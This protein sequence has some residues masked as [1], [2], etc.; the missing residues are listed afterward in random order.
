MSSGNKSEK[1]VIV[2]FGWIGQ[3]NALAL[4][5]M[6]F[7]V[8]YY[9][10]ITPNFH[11]ADKYQEL[12]K[13]IK[14]LKTLLEV[15]SQNTWYIVCIGDRV[16]ED[17]YQ[18]I[19]L[20]EQALEPLRFARGK[21]ILRSTVLP[22]YLE[23]LHFHI[24][25]PEFLH[26]LYAVE[27]CLNPF[28]YVVGVREDFEYPDFFK[29]WEDR[30]CKIFKG[31]PEEA[32]HIKY[33]S[34]IWNAMR[35][36]FVNEFG[37]NIAIPRSEE[38]FYKVERVVDFFFEK[39]SY[40][41]YGKTFDGHCLPKDMR[42]FMTWKG[43]NRPVPLLKAIYQSNQIHQEVVD[44]YTLPKW[45][46]AWDYNVYQKGIKSR[47]KRWW[48][49]LNSV[50]AVQ[51]VRHFVRPVVRFFERLVPSK[52]PDQLKT[53]WN[54]WAKE[55]PYYYTNPDTK[56]GKKADEFEIRQTGQADYQRYIS[57]DPVLQQHM[58]G[59]QEKTVLE[60]GTGV[61]R[62]TEYF[63]QDFKQVHGIDISP[64]MLE[65]AKKRMASF[66]NVN[67]AETVGNIIPFDAEQFDLIFSY[68]V[69]KHLRRKQIIADYFKE[70]A[71]AL[72][73]DGLVKVQL[74]TG[75]TPHVWHWFYG[76]SLFLEEAKALAE[77]SGFEI[78]KSEIENPKSMWLWLKKS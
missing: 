17:G 74:R 62:M 31:T 35:I 14:P 46:S 70:M 11:Y 64:V 36:A 78:V 50:K 71:V 63:A 75:T 30:S 34:N 66:D 49:R 23:R 59:F 77:R 68:L 45:F 76:V 61:G 72:K 44:N 1:I 28:Y 57:E 29:Q 53:K 15:D 4:A 42:A 26:E 58:G 24:Y 40:L 67:L 52:S 5:R 73:K 19:S 27:E 8:F 10:V 3:A 69:F 12:Y 22:K 39:K 43:E 18:D 25:L 20:I 56:S 21:T 51:A 7:D 9:D 60:I 6:N 55:N 32:S 16:S 13:K 38:D 47:L 33:L 37:D 41:R 54:Q 65:S 48:Q 2:G